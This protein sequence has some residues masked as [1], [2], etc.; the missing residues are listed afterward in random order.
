MLI[1]L[2]GFVYVN[3]TSHGRSCLDAHEDDIEYW[4][5]ARGNPINFVPELDGRYKFVLHEFMYIFGRD[6][7]PGAPE[8]FDSMEVEYEEPP[9]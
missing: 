8:L 2:N 5:Q 4:M 3:L 7:L 9:R 6:S 1:N